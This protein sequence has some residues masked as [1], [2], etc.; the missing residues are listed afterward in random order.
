MSS[1]TRI[2]IP[3]WL[4][5]AARS[6]PDKLALSYG[7]EHWSF[8]GL[9]RAADATAT[10]LTSAHSDLNGRIGILSANRPGFVFAVHA[11]TALG[12][13]F[14]PLNW[15]QTDGEIAWQLRDANITVLVVDQERFPVAHLACAGR[16]ITI[17]PVEEVEHATANTDQQTRS[18]VETHRRPSSQPPPSPIAMGD[19]PLQWRGARGGAGPG[20]RVNLQ[21]EAAVLYTSGTSGRP[22]GA[23]LTYGN[24]WFSAVASALHLGHHADDIW[25]AAMPLFHVGGLSILFRGVITMTPVI[26]HDQFDPE[27]SLLAIDRG[28]TLVSVVPAMLQRMIE[29]REKAPWPEHLRCVLLGGSAAP[30]SLV[31]DCLRLGIPVAPTYG[32]TETASQAATLLPAETPQKRESSGR[33]LPLTEVRIAASSGNASPNDIGEIEVRGPTIFA[34]YLDD[35]DAASSRTTDGWFRTGDVGYLDDDGFL[36]VVDRRDD[37]IVSGGEN[38]YPAE[39]ER[40]LREHPLVSDA[41]VIGV[42]DDAWG[43]RPIAAVVWTGDRADASTVLHR[44]CVERLGRYKVPDR[45]LLVA[46]IP[47]S[48]SGKLLRRRLRASVQA[49]RGPWPA[50]PIPPAR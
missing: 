40:V 19:S 1:A 34:G 16:S 33:P 37:L 23:R 29:R 30:P 13:P 3:N 18:Q 11:A 5:V 27:A 9:R 20:V 8:A 44:H 36:Y 32:L 46:E 41:A 47:R 28:A 26:L 39:I 14:V 7:D 4:D 17:V 25:L 6:H 45:I 49:E 24:L 38:V 12:V 50:E 10:L 15:R 21:H 48:S 35:P 31:D 43:S 22:K 42:A 2:D